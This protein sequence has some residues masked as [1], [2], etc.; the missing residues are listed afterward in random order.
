MALNKCVPGFTGATP[1]Y[2]DGSTVKPM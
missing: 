2:G 1:S